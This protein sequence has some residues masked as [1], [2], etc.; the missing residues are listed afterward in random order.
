[1]GKVG[2]DD[3]GKQVP[4]EGSV[5]TQVLVAESLHFISWKP[6]ECCEP[7]SYSIDYFFERLFWQS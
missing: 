6:T 7:G 3:E 2:P 1:M 4:E 5:R